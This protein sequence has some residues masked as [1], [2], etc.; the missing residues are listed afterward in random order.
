MTA[1]GDPKIDATVRVRVPRGTIAAAADGRLVGE[2]DLAH[3]V[4][5]WYAD[6][7]WPVRDRDAAEANDYMQ[8]KVV[9]WPI[10]DQR[11]DLTGLPL[12]GAADCA[13]VLAATGP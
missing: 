10:L 2:V 9:E 6:M 4:W 8:K 11:H 13:R 12:D 5:V 1:W 3:D 7:P